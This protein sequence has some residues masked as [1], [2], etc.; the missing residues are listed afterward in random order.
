[1]LRRPAIYRTAMDREHYCTSRNCR[2]DT[3]NVFNALNVTPP[4][5]CNPSQHF[6]MVTSKKPEEPPGW[7]YR[8]LQQTPAHLR[9]A[10]SS[11]APR[12]MRGPMSVTT[13]HACIPTT[14][15]EVDDKPRPSDVL[16]EL[17]ALHQLNKDYSYNTNGF[18]TG[19][20]LDLY[21]KKG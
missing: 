7:M 15:R 6:P 5:V 2:K 19:M 10:S 11:S 14:Y 13:T 16:S 9:N 17:S 20:T 1:M 4:M 3:S 8:L 18:K 12:Y 21:R